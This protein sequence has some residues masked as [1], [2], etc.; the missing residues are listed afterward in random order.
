M[1]DFLVSIHDRFLSHH[2][3]R[4]GPLFTVCKFYAV[5]NTSSI[6]G[7][8][9]PILMYGVLIFTLGNFRGEKRILNFTRN[10]AYITHHE[11]IQ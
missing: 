3:F 9:G 7:K 5:L 6:N 4:G 2:I 1:G 11:R 10:S 8:Y